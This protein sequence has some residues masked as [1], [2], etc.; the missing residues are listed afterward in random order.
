MHVRQPS[1]RS[2]PARLAVRQA[3]R[4]LS[5]VAGGMLANPTMTARPGTYLRSRLPLLAVAIAGATLARRPPATPG[6]DPRADVRALVARETGFIADDVVFVSDATAV[7]AVV[8]DRESR[9]HDLLRVPIRRAPNGTVLG[10]SRVEPIA[11][12]TRT[13]AVDESAP[14]VD[15]THPGRIFFRSGATGIEAR[16]L[17]AAAPPIADGTAEERLRGAITRF[18]ETGRFGGIASYRFDLSPELAPKAE[19]A[20]LVATAEGVALK[21]AGPAGA[22][23]VT[24]RG[25]ALAAEPPSAGSGQWDEAAHPPELVP[26]AVDRVRGLSF[27]G[28]EK[29]QWIKA[30]AYTAWAMIGP[31]EAPEP[32][33]APAIPAPAPS[34]AA[35]PNGSA[36]PKPATP[37]TAGDPKANASASAA[38]PPPP[39]PPPLGDATPEEGVFQSLKDD[40][41][42]PAGAGSAFATTSFRVDKNRPVRVWIAVW[43]PRK[44]ELRMVAGTVEPQS[45]TGVRGTGEIPRD[46]KQLPR[47]VAAFNGGFQ[48]LHG[49]Y[50]MQVEGQRL[51]AP[52]AYA[53]TVLTLKDGA[54]AYGTWPATTDPS[55]VAAGVPSVVTSF[56]QNM[57]PLVDG[58]VLDPWGRTWWGGTPPGWTDTIHTV[59]SAIG[60]TREGFAIYAYSLDISPQALGEALLAARCDYGIHLDMNGGQ[61]GF[62]FLRIAAQGGITQAPLGRPLEKTWEAEGPLTHAPAEDGTSNWEFRARRLFRGM[63]HMSFPRY[64]RRDGRDFFYLVARPDGTTGGSAFRYFGTKPIPREQWLPIQTKR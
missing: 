53:A 40:P 20:V 12:I 51:L 27:V 6:D 18:Q 2:L 25:D 29:M 54:T 38:F 59:R 56:R 43:D 57:T 22:L 19:D 44:I 35:P 28:D 7:A 39:V 55:P 34:S 9:N 63:A 33:P 50:G 47:V 58:G 41:F 4:K 5:E 48:A 37:P 15:A 8:R 1:W 23:L 30:V 42:L 36:V 31:R 64:V 26:W 60:F 14:L 61:A 32:L 16:D 13:D 21:A 49:G 46:P 11:W 17:F 24:L 52:K 62:E 3:A 10:L 45:T